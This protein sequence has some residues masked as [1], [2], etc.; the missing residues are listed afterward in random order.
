[1]RIPAPGT[2]IRFRKSKAATPAVRPWGKSAV[3]VWSEKKG[4]RLETAVRA[5]VRA[6]SR[7]MY[8]EGKALA[9]IRYFEVQRGLA[10][11]VLPGVHTAKSGPKKG[12]PA[13]RAR[14]PY[15]AAFAAKSRR[16]PKF[17]D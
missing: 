10:P 14:S 5:A 17:G 7:T 11:A 9:R 3:R 6:E 1:M 16:Q 12:R 15:A 4:K 13:K 2:R 8:P